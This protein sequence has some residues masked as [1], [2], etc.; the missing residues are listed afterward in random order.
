MDETISCVFCQHLKED[1][2][3]WRTIYESDDFIAFLDIKPLVQGH[4]IVIPKKHCVWTWDIDDVEGYYGFISEVVTKLKNKLNI[5]KVDM[6]V[7][8]S[9]VP[10][11]HVHLLPSV[12]SNWSKVLDKFRELRSSKDAVIDKDLLEKLKS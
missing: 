2:F 12:E 5:N 10:H 7:S 3:Q 4:S 6:L 11:A 8:G 9:S 1:E